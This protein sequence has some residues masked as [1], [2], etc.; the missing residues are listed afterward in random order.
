M[1]KRKEYL[2]SLQDQGLGRDKIL[3]LMKIYDQEN[4]VEKETEVEEEVVENNNNEQA[5]EV[6]ESD[7]NNTEEAEEAEE[8]GNIEDLEQN[9][10]F[11]SIRSRITNTNFSLFQDQNP[12]NVLTYTQTPNSYMLGLMRNSIR[13]MSQEE[14][15]DTMSYFARLAK[16]G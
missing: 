2:I 15:D 4:P 8:P 13:E 14:D 10:Q 7:E 1:D 5:E 9:D 12:N 3:E 11:S 16:E 6:V